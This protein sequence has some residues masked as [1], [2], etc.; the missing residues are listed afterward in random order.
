MNDSGDMGEKKNNKLVGHLISSLFWFCLISFLFAVS[1]G[2]R[3]WAEAS[4]SD[5]APSER[6]ISL[7]CFH[8]LDIR[9]FCWSFVDIMQAQALGKVG[10]RNL[11]H[12]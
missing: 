8:M 6:P 3:C 5:R 4:G 9:S 10:V 7:S 1:G 11:C 12:I 2:C